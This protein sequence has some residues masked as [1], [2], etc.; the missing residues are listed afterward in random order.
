LWF[1]EAGTDWEKGVAA[2]LGGDFCALDPRVHALA[3]FGW[4][5]TPREPALGHSDTRIGLWNAGLLGREF[6]H[7]TVE[8]GFGKEEYGVTPRALN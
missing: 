4:L 3:A 8:C 7:R 2:A 5:A 1:T 6:P